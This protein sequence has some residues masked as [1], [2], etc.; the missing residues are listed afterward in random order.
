MRHQ[1][2][3]RPTHDETQPISGFVYGQPDRATVRRMAYKSQ[4]AANGASSWAGAIVERLDMAKPLS[5]NANS[6]IAS[7]VHLGLKELESAQNQ[8]MQLLNFI[9]AK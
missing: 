8:L 9:E 1:P 7:C 5:I 6:V 4:L 3:N 2:A